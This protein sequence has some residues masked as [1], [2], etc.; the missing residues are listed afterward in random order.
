MFCD[1]QNYIYINKHDLLET[2]MY[3]FMFLF[4]MTRNVNINTG[5]VKMF[6]MLKNDNKFVVQNGRK[7]RFKNNTEGSSGDV[8][9]VYTKYHL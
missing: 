3:H 7:K 6:V 8:Y 9:D 5:L 2:V 1:V 4:G